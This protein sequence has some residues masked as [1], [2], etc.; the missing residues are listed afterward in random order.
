M[1]SKLFLVLKSPGEWGGLD[2][3]ESLADDD[4]AVVLLN[5][6]VLFALKEAE[7]GRLKELCVDV[8]AMKDDLQGRGIGP[9][10]GVKEID[11]PRLVELIMEDYQQTIT[12]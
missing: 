7:V 12:V 9:A 1:A 4:S 10:Y 3:L 6:A 8:Y 5:D 2:L 11:Y